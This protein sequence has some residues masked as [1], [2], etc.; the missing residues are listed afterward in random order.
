MEDRMSFD[1]MMEKTGRS[2]NRRQ[3]MIQSSIIHD[4]ILHSLLL[5]FCF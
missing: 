4:P 5:V 1:R 2:F 3:P